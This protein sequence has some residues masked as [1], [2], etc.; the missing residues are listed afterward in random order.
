MAMISQVFKFTKVI[1]YWNVLISL[2]AEE[3]ITKLKESHN[4]VQYIY[5]V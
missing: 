2:Q 3:E 5:I 1:L 4:E